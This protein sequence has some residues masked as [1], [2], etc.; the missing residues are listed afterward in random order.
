MNLVEDKVNN[1]VYSKML[2]KC[3]NVAYTN[4]IIKKDTR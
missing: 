4:N 3:C 2:Y 1:L